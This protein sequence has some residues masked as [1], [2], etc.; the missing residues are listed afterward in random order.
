MFT[1]GLS[2]LSE[3]SRSIHCLAINWSIFC[4]VCNLN[5]GST[6]SPDLVI[7]KHSSVDEISVC[8]SQLVKAF[9]DKKHLLH[10][11]VSTWAVP[12]LLHKTDVGGLGDWWAKSVWRTEVLDMGDVIFHRML[13]WEWEA[14]LN[15]EPLKDRAGFVECIQGFLN[16][17]EVAL[18]QHI[19]TDEVVEI[20]KCAECLDNLL[21]NKALNRRHPDL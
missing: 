17:D 12:W 21:R 11:V 15:V 14:L 20:E 7:R 8:C 4:L 1:S 10:V 13:P 19:P 18:I 9:I 2:G 6:V 5:Y 3:S 16:L